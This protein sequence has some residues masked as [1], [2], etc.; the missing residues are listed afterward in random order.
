M[1]KNTFIN[2][3]IDKQIEFINLELKEKPLSKICEELKISRATI[4]RNFLKGQHIYSKDLSQYI[5]L[6]NKVVI[7]YG[8]NNKMEQV[9]RE[10]G[11]TGNEEGLILQD[12]KSNTSVLFERE[13][14]IMDLIDNKDLLFEMMEH[15]KSNINVI[16]VDQLDLGELPQEMKSD[17]INKS[18]KLYKPVVELFDKVCE[19]YPS[20]KKQDMISLA[21]YQF[22]KKFDK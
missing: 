14:D 13:N 16:D 11:S 19:A 20:F 21:I 10:E 1:E 4:Q 17:I 7:S 22:S 6:N 2:L 3:P 18:F 15:Y 12:Y 8:Y 5:A 9:A